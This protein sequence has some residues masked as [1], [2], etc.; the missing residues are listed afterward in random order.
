MTAKEKGKRMSEKEETKAEKAY[1]QGSKDAIEG[2]PPNRF[3]RD[4]IDYMEGYREARQTI[5]TGDSPLEKRGG[6]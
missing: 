1:S 2:F 6:E 3:L 4:N 5:M